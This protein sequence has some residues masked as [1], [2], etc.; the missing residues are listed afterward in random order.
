MTLSIPDSFTPVKPL[1]SFGQFVPLDQGLLDCVYCSSRTCKNKLHANIIY[2]GRIAGMW[3]K[4][5]DDA[6]HEWV[7]VVEIPDFHPCAE[8]NDYQVI[9]GE[10][11]ILKLLEKTGLFADSGAH[12]IEI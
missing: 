1:F 7:Y 6:P 12:L 8:G 10:A 3:V 5:W 2:F 9:C 4:R 11:E